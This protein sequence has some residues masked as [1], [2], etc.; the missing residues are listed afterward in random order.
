TAENWKA[1]R[2]PGPNGAL[3]FVAPLYWWGKA[4]AGTGASNG[5]WSEAVEEAR[6]MLKGL[7]DV[8]KK[9]IGHIENGGEL[10]LRKK[11]RQ[12]L[13]FEPSRELNG[14]S[15][16]DCEVRVS[17][18]EREIKARKGMSVK[19]E[20]KKRKKRTK[21][22][23]GRGG[24]RPPNRWRANRHKGIGEGDREWAPGYSEAAGQRDETAKVY[25]YGDDSKRCLMGEE[26]TDGNR[27]I[28]ITVGGPKMGKKRAGGARAKRP[29]S[30][31]TQALATS[32]S[33]GSRRGIAEAC[34]SKRRIKHAFVHGGESGAGELVEEGGK[35]R[36]RGNEPWGLKIQRWRF[37]E[38]TNTSQSGELDEDIRRNFV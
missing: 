3:S 23:Y 19:K 25:I 16:W 2:H 35:K 17:S 21:W 20:A 7:L 13:H 10:G 27:S 26:S 38:K 34:F 15:K 18:W 8:E 12:G 6:W 14:D 5:A 33:I 29:V 22:E 30:T 37:S 9:L 32:S 31:R 4:V 11:A 24:R 1:M 28:N 36:R